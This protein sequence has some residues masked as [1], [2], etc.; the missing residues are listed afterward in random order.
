MIPARRVEEF[1]ELIARTHKAGMK[2]LIDIV[3]N[4]V[5]RKYEEMD[6]PEGVETLGVKDDQSVT[7]KVK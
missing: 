7:Y 3:P 5:A 1:E 4:H 6:K 2:V